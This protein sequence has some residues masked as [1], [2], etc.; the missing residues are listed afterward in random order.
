MIYD[1]H[2]NFINKNFEAKLFF[3]DTDSLAYQINLEN[4]YEEFFKHKH[5]FDFC[6]FAKNSKFFDE[7]N[8]TLLVKWKISLKKNF[9][10]LKSKMHFIK[11]I[12]GK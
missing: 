12:D 3:T 8:K 10:G 2:Y 4:V 11:Y 1:F 9:V 6:N 5:L 7:S